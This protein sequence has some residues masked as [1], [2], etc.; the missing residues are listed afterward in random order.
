MLNKQS[1]TVFFEKVFGSEWTKFWVLPLMEHGVTISVQFTQILLSKDGQT[2]KVDLPVNTT[3][4]MKA[5]AN[6]AAMLQAKSNVQ[7]LFSEAK[8]EWLGQP[9]SIP[10][11]KFDP[12]LLV[13]PPILEEYKDL[14]LN[15]DSVTILGVGG[16]GV[17][18]GAGVKLPFTVDDAPKDLSKT[19]N[20]LKKP[21][22]KPEKKPETPTST[23][24]LKLKDAQHI[25]QKVKGTG[26][27]SVYTVIAVNPRVKVA[28]RIVNTSLSLR[29]EFVN[30]G[31]GERVALKSMGMKENSAGHYSMHMNCQDVPIARALG[32]FLFDVGIDFDERINSLKDIQK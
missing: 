8:A 29:A 12:N 30:A 27:D 4:L 18:S 31:I 19:I 23:A 7:K 3:A 24:V 14:K 2:K 32:A 28:A 22:K 9:L 26:S 17:G 21:Q 11:V 6:P 20:D 15:P 16:G 10:T 25:G 13:P 5:S 1:Q